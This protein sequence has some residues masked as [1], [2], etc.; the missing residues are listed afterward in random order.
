MTSWLNKQKKQALLDLSA[1]AGLD[2]YDS[3]TQERRA[4]LISNREGDA[5][6]DDLVENLDKHLQANATRLARNSSFQ[7]YFDTRRTPFKPRASSAGGGITS[8]DDEV[9]SVVK[10]RG[11]RTTKVKPDTE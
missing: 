3:I 8:G 4:L 2:Q 9:K 7:P 1:E 10:A 6:K 11:R 5:R